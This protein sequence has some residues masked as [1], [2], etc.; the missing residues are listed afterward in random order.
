LPLSWRN[1]LTAQAFAPGTSIA[2]LAKSI[3]NE[4]IALKVNSTT[5]VTLPTRQAA[6]ASEKS[7][8]GFQATL[9]AA[10]QSLARS[11]GDSAVARPVARGRASTSEMTAAEY[12]ADYLRKGPAQ[13]LRE[14]ILKEMGLSEADL[15]AMPP[16]QRTAV[17]NAIAEKIRELMDA[18]YGS[19]GGHANASTAS[20]QE[21]AARAAKRV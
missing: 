3:L 17:E 16:G 15:D 12:L 4:E 1:P 10:T 18:Q 9:A 14:A 11:G 21:E 13:H 6:S 20:M 19:A 7:L 5:D 8:A 2:S